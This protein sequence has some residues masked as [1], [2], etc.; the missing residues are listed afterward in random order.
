MKPGLSPHQ[1][2][3]L[4]KRLMDARVAA[5][6]PNRLEACQR[7][8]FNV[9][10]FKAHEYGQRS[11][12]TAEAA[13]YASAFGVTVEHL[14]STRGITPSATSANPRPSPA[15]MAEVQRATP[16]HTVPTPAVGTHQPVPT[17]TDK[18]RGAPSGAHQRPS[19]RTMRTN[20]G[21]HQPEVPV[22]GA[23]AFGIWLSAT[24]TP[25]HR[26]AH[27]PPAPGHPVELQY[28][29]QA[30]GNSRSDLY[31][32]GDYIIFRRHA[33]GRIAAGHYDI[34]RRK[35]ALS[36]SSI[37]VFAGG[38]RMTSDSAAPAD[39]PEELQLDP[40]DTTVS[41]EGVAIAVFRPIK[42]SV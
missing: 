27:I 9:N 30:V 16:H 12:D 33:G 32:D 24:G 35:G 7:F 2:K 25:L 20:D 31:S 23:S 17:G 10:T 1:K 37:W 41:V 19:D 8:G 13:R 21:A 26:A 18:S 34:L 22:T 36:E 5:G 29:R 4:G 42:S 39:T 28:A 38:R 14:T 6:H 11:F 40:D 15:P 3:A